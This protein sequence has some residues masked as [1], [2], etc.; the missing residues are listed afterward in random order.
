M[1]SKGIFKKLFCICLAVT[2]F[3][4]SIPFTA[5]AVS[6]SKVNFGVVSDVHYFAETSMGSSKTAF[7][8]MSKL[9]NSTTYAA[10]GLLNCVLDYY[11]EEALAGNL[12]F[13]LIPGDLTRNAEVAG[14][15]ALAAKLRQF[16]QEAGIPVYVIDGNHDINNPRAGR[17]DGAQWIDD[18]YCT[19]E[20][21]EEI[22]AEFGYNEALSRYVPAKG[23]YEGYLSYTADLGDNYRLISVDGSRYSADN[24]DKGIDKQ[25]TAGSFSDNLLKWVTEECKKAEAEGRTVIGMNHF[26]VVPHFETEE[27][28]FEAFVLKEWERCADTLADAGMHY[29]FSGHIHMHDVANYVSDNGETITDVATTSLLSYPNEFRTVSMETSSDGKITMEYTTHDVDERTP[30]VINGVEQPKPFKY[31]TWDVNYGG[32]NI[33]TFALNFLEYQLIYGFGKDVQDAGGL[34][35][36]LA[37]AVDFDTLLKE[38]TN[39]EIL[40]GISS[41]AIKLLLVSICNQIDRKYLQDPEYVI[42]TLEPM[43]DELLAIEVSDYPCTKFKSTL[44]FG[45]DNEKGNIGDLVSTVLAYHYTND[46]DPENDKFLMSALDRFD[47]GQNAEVILDTLLKVVL[48]DLIQGTI[49]KDIKIDP[50]SMGLNGSNPEILESIVNFIKDTFGT[51]DFSGIGLGDIISIVLMSGIVGGDTLS[52][53]VY[54]FLGEYLTQSQYDIIDSEFYRIVKDLT[55]DQ[56]P[57]PKMDNN[58]KI[59]YSGKAKVVA[60]SD[61]LRLPSGVA[62]TFG[63]DSSATRNISYFTKYSVTRTDVQIVPYSSNPDFSKGS[64]VKASVKTNCENVERKYAGIDFGVFGILDHKI[65]I[66]RHTV[67]ISGLKAGEKYSYR[68]GDAKRGWWSDAGVIETADNSTAFSFFHMTDPQSVTEKQ[69]SNNWAMAVKTAF[70]LHKN[71][72]FILGT[73]DLVDNGGNFN[74]WKRMF[75]TASDNLMDTAL[76]TATGNHEEKGDNAITENFIIPNAPEQ[77]TTKGVYYSFDYNTA[78]FAILNTN[79]LNDDG[80]IGGEQLEWLKNDMSSSKKPWK[81]VALH[82]APYSNGAHFDDSDVIALRNQLSALMPELGVDMVFQGH[83]HVYMR[84]DVMKNNEVVSTEKQTLTYNGLEYASKIKPDGTIY[85]INGTAGVK[86]YEPKSQE[87][88]DAQFPAGETVIN[89]QIP[90]YSYIQIDGGNLYFDS[91]AVENGKESRIDSFAISKVVTL[92]NGTTLDGTNGNKE[93]DT[94][95]EGTTNGSEDVTGNITNTSAQSNMSMVT[96]VVAAVSLVMIIGITATIIVIKRRREEV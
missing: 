80:T 13:V 48:D 6:G 29:M 44:G 52:G 94:P 51:G 40:G 91:Y 47:K 39:S 25:E 85:S 82:K 68:V 18:E 12:D 42:T 24:T 15:R 54:S 88:T 73:G 56:N 84:T 65:Y 57:A 59:V 81:F 1:K 76:M 64:T 77:D 95:S 87:E 9:D 46:E 2:V 33:K 62:V 36:Y 70:S 55:H 31:E 27:D 67:E 53:V 69:Y 89:V 19:P 58:G 14:H 41:T 79:A 32:D 72:D 74:H 21:F 8:E 43:L 17:F 63:D 34:Y 10:P 20:L 26:N 96:I 22:Y 78:H 16:E 3:A 93:I 30:V 28:L 5:L 61:N 66:N 92:E 45:S 86:H 75:N 35:N 71:S 90:S 83:D 37:A 50:I 11:K 38:L 4:V 7:A 49:L 60:T 23:E